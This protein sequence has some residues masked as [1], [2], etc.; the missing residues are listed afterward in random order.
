M[1][2]FGF[3]DPAKV[4]DEIDSL[5]VDIERVFNDLRSVY[6][7]SVPTA[8]YS[9]ANQRNL[10]L[11]LSGRRPT[12]GLRLQFRQPVEHTV[13]AHLSVETPNGIQRSD[14]SGAVSARGHSLAI[15]V[16]L[17][18]DHVPS[19]AIANGNS[20]GSLDIEAGDYQ[21]ELQGVSEGN[22]LDGVFLTFGPNE[23]I[24]QRI[25]PLE[26]RAVLLDPGYL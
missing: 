7:E 4:L 17:L 10:Q 21:L 26:A 22:Q 20:S 11:R 13:T 6:V 19:T 14:V 8:S 3:V 25:A 9:S 18:A 15:Q 2:E 5:R 23:V 1:Y 24:A 12:E 16:P